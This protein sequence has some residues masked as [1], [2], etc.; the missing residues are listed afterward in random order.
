MI[1]PDCPTR[2]EKGTLPNS[3]STWVWIC[4]P[5]QLV[6]G[7]GQVGRSLSS[8]ICV[9][10]S[11]HWIDC[12]HSDVIPLNDYQLKRYSYLTRKHK[13]E[14][15]PE[16]VQENY[17]SMS[18]TV[19]WYHRMESVQEENSVDDEPVDQEES[20]D[21]AGAPGG[22]INGLT[23]ICQQQEVCLRKEIESR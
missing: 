3:T 8:D 6:H 5:G 21:V 15:D 1:F 17:P 20:E 14:E 4:R 23:L 10:T 11:N 18:S 13:P 19:L 16:I 7:P 9:R 12:K 2:F 22:D